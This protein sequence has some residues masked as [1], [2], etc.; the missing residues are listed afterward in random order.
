MDHFI[1]YTTQPFKL[2]GKI[3]VIALSR[4]KVPLRLCLKTSFFGKLENFEIGKLW[5][6]KAQYLLIESLYWRLK[7]LW[8]WAIFYSETK[9]GSSFKP[10]CAWK[11]STMVCYK[12][13]PLESK[14]SSMNLKMNW[15][16][17]KMSVFVSWLMANSLCNGETVNIEESKQLW[18]HVRWIFLPL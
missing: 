6:K 2:V 18:K 8:A 5:H 16:F 7:C 9:I 12:K 17:Q 3:S 10:I 4:G 1:N 11:Y 15:C 14:S 13:I